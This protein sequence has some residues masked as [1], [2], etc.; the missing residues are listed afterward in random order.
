MDPNTALQ[1]TVAV[2]IKCDV[3][4]RSIHQCDAKVIRKI[5]YPC[6]I[7]LCSQHLHQ[8]FPHLLA[9]I[10]GFDSTPG[11]GLG[12]V[13]EKPVYDRLKM[14]LLPHGPLFKLI[15]ILDNENYYYEFP[16]TCLPVSSCVCLCMSVVHAC[17]YVTSGA[18][19]VPC[20]TYG[21]LVT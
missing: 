3:V 9:N 21:L 13:L 20:G 8:F 17:L 18:L 19:Q 15:A 5:G 14:F 7:L 12:Q 11:W 10:F 2:A 6:V 1:A 16:T 4:E